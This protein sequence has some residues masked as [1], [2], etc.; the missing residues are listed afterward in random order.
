MS[1]FFC[2]FAPDFGAKAQKTQKRKILMKRLFTI[3][4]A[5]MM[6]AS[7][8]AQH[9]IG[10]I[11]GGI[12]GLSYKYWCTDRLAVQADLAVGLTVAPGAVYYQ[13][14][15]IAEGTNQHYDFTFNPNVAYHFPLPS[16]LQLYAGCGVNIGLLSDIA[17]VESHNLMGKFGANGII[18]L[19]WLACD[20]VAIAFD[21]RPGYGLGFQQADYPLF[22]F[23][24]WKVG[25]AVR[26]RI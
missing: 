21:F 1:F 5:V 15:S 2:I 24:D 25:L 17:N 6:T 18:G 8:M 7:V 10:V 14:Y 11:A 16:D 12:N 22:H 19:L 4:A 9:E 26:Y 13:G 23:F 3:L 20:K